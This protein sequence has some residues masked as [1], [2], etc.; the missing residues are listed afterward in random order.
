MT[1][2]TAE[3]LLVKN[4]GVI[5]EGYDADLVILDYDNLHDT[6]TYSNSNSL[7]E[8]IDYVIVGGEVV[9]HDMKLT[10]KYPGKVIRHNI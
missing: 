7:T 8:G 5:K 3:Y 2:L 1:G 4:K 9:Y 10:G 6:A